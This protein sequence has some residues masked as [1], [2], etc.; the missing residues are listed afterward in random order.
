MSWVDDMYDQAFAQ[1]KA[2]AA[3]ANSP[4]GQALVVVRRG[5]DDAADLFIEQHKTILDYAAQIRALKLR[6]AELEKSCDKSS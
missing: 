6:I 2:L 4:V 1:A 5:G 3:F